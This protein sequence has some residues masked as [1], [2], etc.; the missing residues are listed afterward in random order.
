MALQIPTDFDAFWDGVRREADAIPLALEMTADPLRSTNDVSVFEVYF[1][2]LDQLRIAGWYC[3]PAEFSGTLPALLTVPGYQADTKIPLEWARRGYAVLNVAVRG[4]LRSHQQFYPGIPNLLTHNIGDRHSYAY[5]GI[6]ADAWRGLDVLLN[7][8]EVDPARVG[9]YGSSQSGGLT[10]VTAA[11]RSEIKA[12]SVGAPFL[13]GVDD[14]IRLTDAYPYQEINDVL[15][16]FPD[17]R[18]AVM[19]TL[20]Y[21]DGLHFADKISC[22]L[23]MNIGLRDNIC[24]PQAGRAV[25]DAVS[26]TDKTL[27]P[28]ADQGHDAGLHLH[29]PVIVE[30]L[31]RHLQN[32]GAS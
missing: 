32:G 17:Q 22:P 11:L 9:M 23:I 4:K 24:P 16:V 1:T 7:L 18:D 5:R 21:F 29:T 27:Y 26:S 14:A 19:K 12:A 20:S 10:V 6:Y 25:F 30:F 8:P 13:C 15:R 28:Y 3:R 2:S 31:A